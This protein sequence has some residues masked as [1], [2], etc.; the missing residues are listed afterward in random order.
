MFEM[1]KNRAAGIRL[2]TNA[3]EQTERLTSEISGKCKEKSLMVFKF[4]V[5][6]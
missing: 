5:S 6:S 1:I 3:L 4:Q 2:S